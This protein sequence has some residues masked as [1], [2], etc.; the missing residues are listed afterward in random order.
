ML[1]A[2]AHKVYFI[3]SEDRFIPQAMQKIPEQHMPVICESGGAGKFIKA[4]LLIF[5]T[6]NMLKN[7]DI[8]KRSDL[9]VQLHQ[10]EFAIHKIIYDENCWKIK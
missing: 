8:E 7:S 9:N 10:Q 2:G 5:L 6:N 1:N 4:G 3:Q